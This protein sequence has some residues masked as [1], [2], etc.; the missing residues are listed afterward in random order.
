MSLSRRQLLTFWRRPALLRPPG[1]I[2]E[3][4]F[5]EQCLACGKCAE[6]CPAEAVF[7]QRDLGRA[8]ET[9]VIDPAQMPC[10]LCTGLLCTHACPT[11]ALKP[12]PND[13][14]QRAVIRTI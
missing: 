14:P 1:A 8:R 12:Y 9:P 11:G 10:V 4:A 13:D 3:A 6:V 2:A 5:L 7:M